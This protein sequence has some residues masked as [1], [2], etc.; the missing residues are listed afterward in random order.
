MQLG[1]WKLKGMNRELRILFA[2]DVHSYTIKKIK[3]YHMYVHS[4]LFICI[5]YLYKYIHSILYIIV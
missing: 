1:E 4:I 3:V 2:V 5:V